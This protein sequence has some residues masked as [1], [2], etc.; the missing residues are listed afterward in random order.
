MS[1]WQEYLDAGWAL[2]ELRPGTKAPRVDGWQKPGAPFSTSTISAGLVHQFSGTC[3]LDIDNMARAELWLAE[4]GIDI[5]ALLRAEDRVEIIGNPTNHGKLIYRLAEPLRSK[6][7]IEDKKNILDFRCVGNQDVLPPSMHP[8]V[9]RPYAWHYGDPALG[10]WSQLPA[11]PAALEALWRSMLAPATTTQAEPD[12]G[13]A[14][15]SIEDLT[16]WLASKD[17]DMDREEWVKVGM[18]IHEAT[19]GQGFYIWDNWS[20]KGEKYKGGMDLQAPWRSFHKGGGLGVGPILAEKVAAPTDFPIE[21][22][23]EFAPEAEP[24]DMSAGAV[25][26]RLLRPRLVFLTSQSKFYFLPGTPALKHLDEH[27]NCGLKRED[28]NDV[29]FRFMPEI[30]TAK[31][32]RV[33]RKPLDTWRELRD[34]QIVDNIGF[35]PGAPR[36]YKDVDGLTYLN[37]F[38]PQIVQPLKPKPH[39]IEAWEFLIGRIQDPHYRRW[40]LQF[41]AF[42]LKNPGVKVTQAPLLYSETPGTGKSTLMNQI[43]TLLYGWKYVNAVSNEALSKSFNSTLADSWFIVLDELKTSGGRQ[44]RVQLANKMKPW[45]TDAQLSIERKG[46]D[47]Y[48][49]PNRLQITATSNFEDAVQINDDDRRWAVCEMSGKAFTDAEI[50]D[51]YEGFLTTPRAAG[52]LR[53]IFNEIDV[54]GFRPTGKAPHTKG[55]IAAVGASLGQWETR[56]I[57]TIMKG[58][59]PFNL[60][61][62]TLSAAREVLLGSNAPPERRMAGLLKKAPFYATQLR[63]NGARLYCWRNQNQ[64]AL[65]GPAAA[66]HYL[67]TSKRP[68]GTWSDDVPLAIRLMAGD[69]GDSDPNID[70]LGDI[71]VN[72]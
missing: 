6:K 41:Y 64:W 4:H 68:A 26:H 54:T 40:L 72:T 70:L 13:G 62:V 28:L 44:D 34:P 65:A 46:L 71:N 21:A 56:L 32:G 8:D 58:E 52:V 25:A 18:R 20:R 47:I 33:R 11:L 42:I 48:Q 43:P 1:N 14:V 59:P 30:V 53:H 35:H 22:P 29:F 17:P 31:G 36:V 19:N 63:T 38:I 67:E 5:V 49:V 57:E 60:D 50:A 15:V 66:L 3:A 9:G 16:A 37:R 7:V 61:I 55:R 27:A 2:V 10:H 24:T 39:E 45:I 12:S 51:L 69:D 23:S